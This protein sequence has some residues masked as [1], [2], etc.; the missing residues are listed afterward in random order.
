MNTLS[1]SEIFKAAVGLEPARRSA[2]LDEACAGNGPLRDEVESLLRAHDPEG[3]FLRGP[4]AEVTIDQPI[5]E[6]PGIMVGPYK[7]REQIGE[8]GFGVVYVAEQE[9]PVRR[10]VALKIIKPGMD[11]KDVIARFEAE[12]QALA[13]MDHPNVA[14]VLDAGTTDSGRPYFVMEL[15]QGVAITEFCNKNCLPT[16][17]RLLLF[18]DVCRAVQHAHQK[19]V[20]HRDL[21]PS[22]IMVTLHDGKPV[23]KV[24]DFGVSKALSQ[25]LTE[26]SIYTAYGQMIGTP[27]YMSPEQAEMS[28]LGTDTRSDIYSLGV[29]LYELLTGQTPLDARRLRASAYAE[30]LRIIK[31]EEPPRP[32]MKISTLGEQATVIAQQRHTNVGQLRRDLAGDLDWIVMKCLE[33]DR[34]RR[35]ETASGLARDIDRYLRDEPVDACPPSAAY[36]L[37]KYWRRNRGLLSTA[38]AFAVLL[39]IGTS[40]SSWQAVRA[41]LAERRAQV[42][43]QNEQ[44]ARA[45]AVTAKEELELEAQRISNATLLANEGIEYQFSGNRAAALAKFAQAQKMEPKLNTTYIYRRMLYTDLGLWDMAAVDYAESFRLTKRAHLQT[46][47]EHAILQVYVGDNDASQLACR[48]LLRQHGSS[49]SADDLMYILRVCSLLPEPVEERALM[50]RRTQQLDRASEKPWHQSAAALAYVRTGNAERALEICGPFHAVGIQSSKGVHRINFAIE[51]IALH[52]LGRDV[53]ARECLPKVEAAIDEWTKEMLEGP[54]GTM[55]LTWT[56]WLQCL[57]LHREAKILLTGFPPAEDPR[58]AAVRQRALE[59]AASDAYLFVDAGKRA[60]RHREWDEAA[61]QFLTAIDKLPS[62]ARPGPVQG[63]LYVEMIE[64]PEVF[65]R[66]IEKRPDLVELRLARGRLLASRRQWASAAEDLDQAL[67]ML[68]ETPSDGSKFHFNVVLAALF[69][70]AGDESRYHALCDRISN[71]PLTDNP[72]FAQVFS[73]CLTLS[74]TTMDPTV[75][76]RL[77]RKAVELSPQIAWHQFALGAALYRAGEY[78]Q[79]TLA[80]EESLRI[81]PGWLG[82]AQNH[83]FL[84][85]A[86]HQLGRSEAARDSLAKSRAAMNE[87]EQTIGRAKH[88]FANSAYLSDWLAI[89]VLLPEAEALIAAEQQ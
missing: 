57:V 47:Y 89:L 68:N 66:L 55:P 24:I 10:K 23:A 15:V 74:P 43:L 48:E 59:V 35:Y 21:K 34:T 45:D 72:H 11:T 83:V 80:L 71:S 46:C 81:Q 49:S 65:Q 12:R 75:P 61:A 37:A 13:L 56:D 78:E 82:R 44:Q 51:A 36:R 41:T 4:A 16:R 53:E 76:L 29:L 50:L 52:A 84:A 5:S 32:S 25:H 60:I 42:A 77:A 19:G 39:V 6:R 54:V 22:N 8:G 62:I 26:K 88:G 9:K 1:D 69:L 58:L 31:E 2:F 40:I 86:H 38:A 27:S 73:R 70:L 20:I 63:R 64:Q 67:G 85:M 30:V 79:A 3:S 33:K 17:E 18:A 87:L 14:R 7:L 28:G